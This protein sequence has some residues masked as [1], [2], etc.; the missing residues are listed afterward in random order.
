MKLAE[1]SNVPEEGRTSDGTRYRLHQDPRSSHQLIA[2]LVRELGRGPIL[3]V[4]AA[5]GL[6]GRL[7]SGSGL[8]IDAVE[9]TPEWALACRP[10]YRHVL[11]S[12]IEQAA[13]AEEKY[14][15]IV[16]ADV[17][18]HTVDPQAVI[19]RLQSA[20]AF[21]GLFIVSLPNIA[22]LAIR[23]L[24]L[25]GKFPMMER[26]ILDRTHLH[27][28]TR[29]TAAQML[30]GAGLRIRRVAATSVPLDELW[31]GGQ[32]N[33]LFRLMTKLQHLLVALFPRL[34]AFQF[35]FLSERAPTARLP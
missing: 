11:A 23:L 6:L 3:D 16:C 24:L 19:T 9:P 34:F 18:E 5:Q 10:Y 26:G 1:Q 17:L 27:F 22:H 29:D 32:G 15:I 14:E 7:L 21:D 20:A 28:Y 30:E 25:A 13:F 8:T 4:G 12:S 35:I 31:K 2:G 33:P